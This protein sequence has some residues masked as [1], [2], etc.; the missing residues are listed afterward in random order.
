MQDIRSLNLSTELVREITE[1]VF[2]DPNPPVKPCDVIFVFGG[3]NPGLWQ[4]AAR[5]FQAGLGKTVVVTGG[6]K[7]GVNHHIAWVDGSTPEADVITRELVKLSVPEDCIVCEN[8]STNSLENVLFAKE[9]YDFSGVKTI[10]AVCKNYGAGRQ[11][12]TL[13]R[14]M[15][16]V[17][18]IPYPFDTEAA[19]SAIFVTRDTWMEHEMTRA[20][21]LNQV[22]KMVRYARL[23]HLQPLE[24]M[25]PELEKLV[26]QW[27]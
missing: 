4:T 26:K 23:G 25:S 15:D 3:T 7:P 24:G 14:Q 6:H 2:E 12:R 10:L 1:I 20:L 19:D 13:R 22:L 18:V 21:V 17:E 16:W 11:C 27:V 8:R 9:V 5:A